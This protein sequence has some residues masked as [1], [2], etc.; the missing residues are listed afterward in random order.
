M[1]AGILHQLRDRL[2]QESN[3]EKQQNNLTDVKMCD[4]LFR[5]I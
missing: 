5:K 3:R 2:H 4:A 1:K